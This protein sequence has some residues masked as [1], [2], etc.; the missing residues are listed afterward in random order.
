VTQYASS[1]AAAFIKKQLDAGGI[2]EIPALGMRLNKDGV[3]YDDPAKEST[4]S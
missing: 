3:I 1:L 2:I 4:D